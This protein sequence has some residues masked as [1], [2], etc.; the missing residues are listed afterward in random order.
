MAAVRTIGSG[1]HVVIGLHGW[2]GSAQGWGWLP[3]LVDPETYTWV[4]PD[5][6]GYGARRHEAGEHTLDE[7]ATDVLALADELGAARFSLLGHS[8]GGTAAARV[9]VRAP[10]RVRSVV[11]VSAVPPT[12]VPF[13]DGGWALFSGAAADDGNRAVII[14]H[15]T[16]GRLSKRWVH[17]M[18]RHSVDASDRTAVGDY[19]TAWARTDF[20]AEVRADDR[21][22]G[23]PVK[24]IVGEHDPALSADV[25]RA[26]WLALFPAAELEVLA[27]AG[28]YAPEETP[29]ALVTSVED[30]L[31][32]AG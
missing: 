9:L 4:L 22:S 23:T 15:T 16:G 3:E 18:V 6:R 25:M 7:I 29:V 19:L 32:Q 17:R 5:Y 10:E 11:G 1:D 30:F 28:H 20:S 2:F 24:V 8:M 27:N 14:D 21:V 31:A 12:G 26:T 13:D